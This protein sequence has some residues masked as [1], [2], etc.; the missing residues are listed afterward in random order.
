MKKQRRRSP[1]S[2][3]TQV[4]ADTELSVVDT[5]FVRTAVGHQSL[6]YTALACPP[7][8]YFLFLFL[9]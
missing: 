1:F 5:L 4:Y 7:I 3:V 2:H 6:A 9:I 8:S